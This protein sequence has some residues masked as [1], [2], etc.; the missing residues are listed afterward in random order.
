MHT[1]M[2]KLLAQYQLLA[3]TYT[4]TQCRHN[5]SIVHATHSHWWAFSAVVH[6]RHPNTVFVVCI[7]IYPYTLYNIVCS[8]FKPNE[9]TIHINLCIVYAI[10]SLENVF[11]TLK[12]SFIHLFCSSALGLRTFYLFLSLFMSCVWVDFGAVFV[13]KRPAFSRRHH[14]NA[15]IFHDNDKM[16]GSYELFL[17]LP[18]PTVFMLL[19]Q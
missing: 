7:S 11:H 6:K 19:I 10:L 16:K 15:I 18:L 12:V 9:C 8:L 17:A 5:V 4:H 1:H 2:L 3:L 14:N 13:S